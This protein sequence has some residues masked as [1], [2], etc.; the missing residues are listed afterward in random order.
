[1]TTNL[2]RKPS[3]HVLE[4]HEFAGW[5]PLKPL[6]DEDRALIDVITEQYHGLSWPTQK[7]QDERLASLEGELVPVCSCGWRGYEEPWEPP[8]SR[9]TRGGCQFNSHE[10][11]VQMTAA[12]QRQAAKTA[13]TALRHAAEAWPGDQEGSQWLKERAEHIETVGLYDGKT[14]P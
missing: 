1:M 8:G 2:R 7:I 3:E 4:G 9:S 6:S 11:N 12:T 13:A 14:W 10:L 5:E